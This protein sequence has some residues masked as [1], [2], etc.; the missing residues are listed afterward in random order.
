MFDAVASLYVL[1]CILRIVKMKDLA[2]TVAAA[3][4]CHIKA[5]TPSSEARL[6]GCTCVCFSHESQEASSGVDDLELDCGSLRL[7]QNSTVCLRESIRNVSLHDHKESHLAL[8]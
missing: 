1:C 8:R 7:A 4:F 3:L 5:F 2:N 6:N